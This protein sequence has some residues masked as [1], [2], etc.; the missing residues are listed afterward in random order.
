MPDARV[1]ILEGQGHSADITAPLVIAGHVLPFLREGVD[2]MEDPRYETLDELLTEFRQDSEYR[3][4]ERKIKPFSDISARLNMRRHYLGLSQVELARRANTH[5]SR[6]SKIESGNHDVRI[7]TLIEIAEALGCQVNIDFEPFDENDHEGEEY[8]S[9]YS[10]PL[11]IQKVE[12]YTSVISQ[13][14]DA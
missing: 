8:I 3:K 13:V 12:G 14:Q 1:V 5:Q 6:V 10:S 11:R 4:A 2:R 9:I 7:S